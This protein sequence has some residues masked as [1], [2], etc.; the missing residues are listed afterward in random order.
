MLQ[1]GVIGG[2]VRVAERIRDR[3]GQHGA[4]RVLEALLRLRLDSSFITT[5]V[6]CRHLGTERCDHLVLEHPA[7]PAGLARLD[8]VQ[9]LVQRSF[10]HGPKTLG[11]PLQIEIVNLR[12]EHW[13]DDGAPS[14]GAQD[15]VARVFDLSQIGTDETAR[16]QPIHSLPT[17]PDGRQEQDRGNSQPEIKLEPIC[18]RLSR[19]T[20][21]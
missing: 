11:L 2:H 16:V 20:N 4:N 19:Q 13:A 5:L 10:N 18:G 6:Y 17:E 14:V 12:V 15:S 1:D 9:Q 3:V 8:A 7:D 21:S